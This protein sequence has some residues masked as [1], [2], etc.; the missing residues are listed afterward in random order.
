V[1]YSNSS[2]STIHLDQVQILPDWTLNI[3]S[4][5]LMEDYRGISTAIS[6]QSKILYFLYLRV[7]N[8]GLVVYLGADSSAGA[9]EVDFTTKFSANKGCLVSGEHE[10]YASFVSFNVWVVFTYYYKDGALVTKTVGGK[11]INEREYQFDAVMCSSENNAIHAVVS[12]RDG[13]DRNVVWTLRLSSF[14]LTSTNTMPFR[15]TDSVLYK[16]TYFG[17]TARNCF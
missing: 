10:N 9:L 14:E 5:A 11:V 4:R 15:I 2:T 12:K 7:D 8:S 16:D 13:R 17:N 1:S 3:T 6:S